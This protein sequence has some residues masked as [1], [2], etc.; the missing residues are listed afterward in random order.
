MSA[1]KFRKK[2]VVIEGFQLT[3]KRRW[4]NSVWPNWLYEAWNKDRGVPGSVFPV[5]HPDSTIPDDGDGG[6]M[7][8]TLEGQ[9]LISWDDWIIQ[10]VQ[11]E[12]R[13]SPHARTITINLDLRDSCEGI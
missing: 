10:G 2:L 7:I 12:S 6:L 9:L 11:G 1:T 4:D 13:S 8:G 3:P 5:Y